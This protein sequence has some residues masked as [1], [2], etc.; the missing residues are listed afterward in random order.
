MVLIMT[1]YI[2][3]IVDRYCL[4]RLSVRVGGNCTWYKKGQPDQEMDYVLS[5]CL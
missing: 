5:E 2:P 1:K 3:E 4:N